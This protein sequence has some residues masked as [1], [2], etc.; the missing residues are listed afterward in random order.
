MEVVVV[1]LETTGLHAAGG[2]RIVEIGAA[3]FRD[4]EPVSEFDVLVNPMRPISPGA[5]R[6]SGLTDDMVADA[7]PI[8]DV[9]PAFFA[10]VS[11]SPLVAH[12]AV[13]D[14][15]FLA[16]AA[17]E[18]GMSPRDN[19]VI[20]TCELSRAVLPRLRSHSL[21]NLVTALD[22]DAQVA[23]RALKDVHATWALLGA[24]LACDPEYSKLTVPEILELQGGSIPW[25]V[26]AKGSGA[27][28]ELPDMLQAAM[29]SGR[30]DVIG[31]RDSAG[32]VTERTIQ[33]LS[34][35]QGGSSIYL[36]AHCHLRDVK[37]TFRLDRILEVR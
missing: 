5:S 36:V 8:R 37:R 28:V 32:V 15:S 21:A 12:N 34:A 25:P 9:L 10:F 26:W 31:Y 7:A 30:T 35:Y 20:C 16:C 33:P 2:D 6:V 23:H 24:L 4:G 22:L 13:F 17:S 14:L 3:R 27:P 11:D 29:T 18:L 19:L 1:D